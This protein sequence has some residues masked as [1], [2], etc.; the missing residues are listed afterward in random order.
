[1]EYFYCCLLLLS[2][3][4][5]HAAV[6]TVYHVMPDNANG[7]A[8][9]TNTHTLQ[10]YISNVDT[11]VTSHSQLIF[12]PGEY[13]LNADLVISNV[14]NFTLSG[15]NSTLKCIGYA[16][17]VVVNV[18]NF[19]IENISLINCGKYL[20]HDL[21]FS[22]DYD[23]IEPS[24]NGSMFLHNCT[25]VLI[26][27]VTIKVKAGNVGIFAVNV[28]G[29]SKILHT[30]II[31]DYTN[32]PK[33]NNHPTQRD[34]VVL[35]FNDGKGKNSSN[36]LISKFHYKAIGVCSCSSQYAIALVLLQK[37]YSV[38]V[39]IHDTRFS[40][41]TNTGAVYYYGETCGLYVHNKLT[42]ENC[43]VSDNTG[44]FTM[45][46]ILLYNYGCFG[47]AAMK[48][49]RNQQYN[50][51]SFIN[52]DFSN[53]FNIS[54]VIYIIPA[55]SW[56]ITGY[57]IIKGSVFCNNIKTHLL[58]MDN[59]IIIARDFVN[60]VIIF[61]TTISSNNHSDGRDLIFMKNGWINFIG[62]I[63]ITHNCLYENVVK[64]HLASAVFKYYIEISHNIARQ[65]FDNLYFL[66]KENTT[67]T[68]FGNIVY[69]IV[70]QT[71]VLTASTHPTCPIQFYSEQ[72]NLDHVTVLTFKI[73]VKYNTLMWSNYFVENNK[74]FVNCMWLSGTAFYN[75]KA[76]D[77]FKAVLN[78][79]NNMLVNETTARIIPMSIC[80][81]NDNERPTC[82]IPNLG[83]VFPGQTVSIGLRVSNLHTRK[84]RSPI[85]LVVINVSECNIVHT[86]QLAQAHLTSGCNVYSYTLWPN[87]YKMVTTCELFIGL[88]D[89]AR[90]VADMFYVTLDHCPIGFT[91]QPNKKA[92]DCDP[93]LENSFLS[94]ESCNVDDGTILRPA[95]SW[96]NADVMYNGIQSYCISKQCPLDYC[97]PY[98]LYIDL[99]VPDMQ[100]QSNRSGVLCGQCQDGLSTVFGSSKCKHCSNKSLFII[101]PLAIA[102]IVL[103]LALFIFNL[104]ITNGTINP[105]IFYV[106]ILSINFSL[107]FPKCP[108]LVNCLLLSL[109][110]LDLGIETCFYDGMDD[111]A[112]T[113][114]RLSFP[115]YLI[116]LAICLIVGSRY[117]TKIQR[118]TAQRALP[119][120][121]TLFLLSYTKIM[122]TVCEVLFCYSSII[123]IPNNSITMIWMVDVSA[124]LF[125]VKFLI[126]F[127]PCIIM[128]VILLFFN[129]L[130]LFARK[131]SHFKVINTFKPLLDAYFGP[132]KDKFYYWTGL[133]LLVRATVLVYQL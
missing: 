31:M 66:I 133:K 106:N 99:S 3:S 13:Y 51:I 50:K 103:V 114:L 64:L 102:G 53:N 20:A 101:A 22:T 121:A 60:Y 94:I 19:I 14:H 49:K 1:M 112:K 27:N 65:L 11:V 122:F 42:I 34:G 97:L 56:A 57:F 46:H 55:N 120:L 85:T 128:L 113:L 111:Y 28:K 24:S 30:S 6:S 58:N 68:I 54:S 48:Q 18:A 12:Q 104:T 47:R 23:I 84:I 83:N 108:Y 44:S 79:A 116:I 123:R 87:N 4:L 61:N 126:A 39:T 35:Y 98:S 131:L 25:S 91:P 125:G 75:R 93:V 72:G 77:V 96:I 127:L 89:L 73:I 5:V 67:I 17:M 62:P 78:A 81:C 71:V 2:L 69:S 92:C 82:K 32:C 40:N 88:S 10:Y 15:S 38:S 74:L 118:L 129:L 16:S 130:L 110:N 43:V 86:S 100:C 132:Y 70:K 26:E 63:V 107:I 105:F 95:K 29:Y 117:S 45:F 59:D 8:K 9:V 124:P 76:T 119:V 80:Q 36:F 90:G 41:F 37:H 21:N 52:C 33:N 7:I 115:L 109:F